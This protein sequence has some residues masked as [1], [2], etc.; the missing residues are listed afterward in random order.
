MTEYQRIT[1]SL[2]ALATVLE[3]LPTL[4]SP[5]DDAFHRE[6]CDACPFQNCAG[7]GCPHQEIRR[8]RVRWWL[9]QEVQPGEHGL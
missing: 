1:A 6:F 8:G 4:G 5:W 9:K 7:D 2:D 3:D